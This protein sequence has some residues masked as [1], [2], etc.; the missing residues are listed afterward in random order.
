MRVGTC[1][2][3]QQE[4]T[5][6]PGSAEIQLLQVSFIQ[7]VWM[8]CYSTQSRSIKFNSTQLKS[9][10]ISSVQFSSVQFSSVPFNSIQ[11]W[12]N[13]FNAIQRGDSVQF[14]SIP[15]RRILIDSINFNEYQLISIPFSSIQSYPIQFSSILFKSD[16]LTRSVKFNGAQSVQLKAIPYFHSTPSNNPKP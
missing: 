15:F 12:F 5:K 7:H 14:H 8:P 3:L 11:F 9:L 10:Q 13:S 6:L 4:S 1:S 2:S 16:K